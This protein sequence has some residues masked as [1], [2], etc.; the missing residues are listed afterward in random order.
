MNLTGFE[1]DAKPVGK[2]LAD[3]VQSPLVQYPLNHPKGV[4]LGALASIVGL[5]ALKGA[6][7]VL[8]DRSEKQR[9]DYQTELLKDIAYGIRDQ[10][11]PDLN[12]PVP[13]VPP[14]R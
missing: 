12:K 8:S 4:L 9:M 14:L 11:T 5:S 3:I 13:I 7:S 6:H 10:S 2:A 1:K